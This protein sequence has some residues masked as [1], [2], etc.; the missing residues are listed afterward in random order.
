MKSFSGTVVAEVEDWDN[1]TGRSHPKLLPQMQTAYWLD[2]APKQP[3][4]EWFVG[5]TSP[6]V[7]LAICRLGPDFDSDPLSIA[8]HLA[9][10]GVPFHTWFKRP[11]D[12][13]Q[14]LGDVRRSPQL[15]QFHLDAQYQFGKTDYDEYVRCCRRLLDGPAG[16]AALKAGG[17]VWRVAMQDLGVRDVIS[18]DLCLEALCGQ[19]TLRHD[20]Q[21]GYL[22]DDGL[23][24]GEIMA[25]CGEYEIGICE[26]G[27]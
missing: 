12:Q 18:G 23:N 20:D 9:E 7:A 5:S 21:G 16:R 2:I 6:E 24:Q 4:C 8:W 26:S 19:R 11:A 27:R 3:Y 1:V 22:V 13:I 17:I 10:K 15:V 25:I 14:P